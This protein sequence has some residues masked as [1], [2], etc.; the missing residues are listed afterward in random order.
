VNVRSTVR[1]PVQLG[2][3]CGAYY[4]APVLEP[5]QDARFWL[6]GLS[7]VVLFGLVVTLVAR[8]VL[9]EVRADAHE[10]HLDRLL[11]T[12]VG[13]V[14]LFALADFV[15]ART[16]PGQ[17]SGLETKTDALYFALTTVTT[18]GY[19]DIHAVAQLARA[20]VIAQMLFNLLVVASAVQTV[21]RELGAPRER[22]TGPQNDGEP[23]DRDDE[24]PGRL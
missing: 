11:L 3:L 13:G 7:A 9:A 24:S 12:V 21:V 1:V 8:E 20:L 4:L 22:S 15:V 2:L 23:T 10:V 19:G 6:R 18:V 16:G 17:F 5:P 14:L